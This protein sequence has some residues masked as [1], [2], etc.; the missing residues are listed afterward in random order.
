M[1]PEGKNITDLKACLNKGTRVFIVD[2]QGQIG[3]VA[4]LRECI[5]KGN[6]AYMVSGQGL[7]E[8]FD[9]L[10]AELAAVEAVLADK[11]EE[12]GK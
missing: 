2:G 7:V 12:S 10:R 11:L 4:D 3:T 9:K 8:E 5:A 6:T 1:P